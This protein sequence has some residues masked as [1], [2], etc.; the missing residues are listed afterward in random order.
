MS[1]RRS[2]SRYD[3]EKRAEERTS[4]LRVR[5]GSRGES[6]GSALSSSVG[7]AVRGRG[8]ALVAREGVG[9]LL[10]VRLKRSSV[11]LV[12]L[13]NK[14]ETHLVRI[15]LSVRGEVVSLSLDGVGGDLGVCDEEVSSKSTKEKRVDEQV[16]C[17]SGLAAAAARS[18]VDCRPASV[19]ALLE[20]A[21]LAWST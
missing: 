20:R 13:E 9:S 12:E 11:K 16:F 21:L 4:L 8:S 3:Y 7:Q 10:G 17:E 14:E 1:T 18:V 15:G 19:K 6:I 5:L 2:V